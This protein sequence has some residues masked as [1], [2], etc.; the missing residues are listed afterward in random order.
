[1]CADPR[2]SRWSKVASRSRSSGHPQ[3]T[4]PDP[5]PSRAPARRGRVDVVCDRLLRDTEVTDFLVGTLEAIPGDERPR[6]GFLH[7]P[8]EI[9]RAIAEVADTTVVEPWHH[10]LIGQ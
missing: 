4:S 2:R 3:P 10:R 8:A 6:F 9:G 1:M 7:R 5:Q